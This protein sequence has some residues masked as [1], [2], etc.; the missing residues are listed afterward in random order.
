MAT[1]LLVGVTL[2][3]GVVQ[4]GATIPV[5]WA[6]FT[7]PGGFIN[8][9]DFPSQTFAVDGAGNV[10][11]AQTSSGIQVYTPST[12]NTYYLDSGH[13]FAG[14]SG[15]A[16]SG[17][18]TVYI[19]Y[20]S[21]VYKVTSSGAE[22]VVTTTLSEPEAL[23]VDPSGNLYIFDNASGNIY[24]MVSGSPVLFHS[25]PVYVNS[26]AAGNGGVLFVADYGSN[27][28]EITTSGVTA[29]GSGW[30]QAESVAVDGA[31]NV[32]V[33]DE[34]ASSLVEV[35]ASGGQDVLTAT[36][37]SGGCGDQVSVG[38]STLFFTDECSNQ[39][40]TIPV[41]PLAVALPRPPLVGVVTS[42]ESVPGPLARRSRPPGWAC[43]A[44][45]APAR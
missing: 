6:S 35:P 29:I 19:S 25:S 26:M 11:S 28:D 33:A 10:Y 23:A 34:S 3:T 36:E 43:P 8:D 12:T 13:D 21:T 24:E 4:A 9:H 45:S 2:A 40:W 31:G 5:S 16:V 18:G 14:Y 42:D 30:D 7:F 44:R 41:T 37:S 38:G 32:Y 39:V 22:S 1:M 15:L 20:G 17:D 27:V